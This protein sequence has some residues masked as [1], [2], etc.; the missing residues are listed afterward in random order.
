MPNYLSP[1]VY[2]EEVEAGSR[3]IEGVGTAV[4]AFVGPRAA[5]AR[6]HAD[7]GHELE[8]VRRHVRR[9]HRGLV[10]RARRLRL[11]PQRRRRPPT[12]SA[13]A[14]TAPMPRAPRLEL[15]SSADKPRKPAFR[16]VALEAGG[17]GNDITVEVGEPSEP[18]EG[19]FKLVVKRGGR[20][21][22]RSTTSR[23][24]ARQAERRHRRSRRSRSSIRIE[25]VAKGERRPGGRGDGRPRRRR[26][27]PARSGSPRTTTSA[28][29]ADRT[30]FGGLEAVD[31]VTMCRVPD[32]MARLPAGRHRPGRASRPSSSR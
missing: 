22:R 9:V 6:E 16:V 11:L 20:A 15:P 10:P 25:E 28:T 12:S 13:S 1:G 23:R 14:P 18:G 3:P 30:G 4:A 7:A 32:L 31:E 19:I 21:A 27:R 24:Q 26:R 8:P 29:S 5:R 2:V 17:A